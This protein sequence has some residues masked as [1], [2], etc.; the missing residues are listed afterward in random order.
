M[1]VR[2]RENFR[3]RN[4]KF[5]VKGSGYTNHC[6]NCLWSKHVDVEPGD[7][8]AGCGGMMEPARIDLKKGE[9]VI[10]HRC[11]KCGHEKKNAAAPDDSREIILK[12]LESQRPL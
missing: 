4:C 10:T 1:F 12:M 11:M 3:C 6:P 2:K 8:A 7:R 5:E 9:Y